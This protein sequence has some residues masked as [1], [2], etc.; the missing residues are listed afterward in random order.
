MKKLCIYLALSSGIIFTSCGSKEESKGD[1]KDKEGTEET[2]EEEGPTR[3]TP[4]DI[5]LS[6]P[7]PCEE[8]LAQIMCW[9]NKT[10]DV[11]GYVYT[12]YGDSAAVDYGSLVLL[13][14]KGKGKQAIS[15]NLKDRDK[16]FKIHK[17]D[18]IHLRGKISG[19]Y[20][21]T[22][23]SMND[24]EVIKIA[25]KIETEKLNPEKA[26]AIFYAGDLQK[27]YTQWNNK[28][29]AV[30]GNYYMTTTSTT[31]YGVTNRVD[32]KGAKSDYA[33]VGCDFAVDPSDKLKDNREGVIV[34]GKIKPG[35]SFGKLQLYDCQL[36]NR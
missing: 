22:L 8:A 35:G 1:S 25:P 6:K 24:V 32:L 9:E 10:V 23:V 18:M 27:D 17:N 19:T 20:F 31:S 30:V 5:D 36:I 21:D 2:T 3:L 34:K 12:Y 13:V 15:V 11:A 4:A 29:I 16:K 14:E 26:G 7:I 28:E 33:D